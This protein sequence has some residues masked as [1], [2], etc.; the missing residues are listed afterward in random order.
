ELRGTA[1]A[2]RLAGDEGVLEPS[3]GVLYGDSYLQLDLRAVYARF[4]ELRPA[5]LMTVYANEGRFDRSNARLDGDRV[6]YDKT[7]EDPEAAGMRHIDYG[8]S[9]VDR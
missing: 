1:G 7:V 2:L 6:L 8:F 3:F 4:D 5:V 9:V